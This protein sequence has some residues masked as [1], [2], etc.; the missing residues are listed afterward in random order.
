MWP[1]PSSSG[2]ARA[3]CCAA[4]GGAFPWQPWEQ[5]SPLWLLVVRR[6]SL[7]CGPVQH[8]L[9][10]IC[11]RGFK[12]T[13]FLPPWAISSSL[14]G[15]CSKTCGWKLRF[16]VARSPGSNEVVLFRCF[17]AL[18]C[19][20]AVKLSKHELGRRGAVCL[21]PFS[22]QDS[23][24]CD[25]IYLLQEVFSSFIRDAHRCLLKSRALARNAEVLLFTCSCSVPNHWQQ[26]R[27]GKLGPLPLRS[28]YYSFH[29]PAFSSEHI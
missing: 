1:L 17:T 6:K 8:G 16:E 9:P 22:R 19:L 27:F 14:A 28:L 12:Q 13:A 18:R 7:C 24:I 23:D 2:E 4:A 20:Q 26:N 10:W 21:W 25:R 11:T 15:G 29:C 5:T 3:A